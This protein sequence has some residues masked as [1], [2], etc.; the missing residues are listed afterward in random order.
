M[1]TLLSFPLKTVDLTEWLKIADPYG[2]FRGKEVHQRL[3]KLVSELKQHESVLIDVT[4]AL[5][6]DY[7]FS[8]FSL[9]PLLLETDLTDQRQYILLGIVPSD[10]NALFHGILKYR[11]TNNVEYS[12][13]QQQ[14]IN[15][16]LTCKLLDAAT[17]S[18]EFIGGCTE[19][20][21]SVLD[22]VNTRKHTIIEDISHALS[23]SHED[24]HD[25]LRELV[26]KG[27]VID[28]NSGSHEYYSFLN[29]L[30]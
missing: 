4:N 6:L 26:R 10:R 3:R 25:A 29:Y 9:A 16:G 30:T 13:S 5:F 18:I 21:R 27:F 19:L 20:E 12:H 14:F 23:R 17:G 11:G 7:D 2:E 15:A 8:C 28:V 1:P 24:V 22:V